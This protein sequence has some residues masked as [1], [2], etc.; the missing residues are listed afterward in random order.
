MSKKA[1]EV[2]LQVQKKKLRGTARL[3]SVCPKCFND[4]KTMIKKNRRPGS[5]KNQMIIRS[6]YLLPK[7]CRK[8]SEHL[9]KCSGT[10]HKQ[11]QTAGEDSCMDSR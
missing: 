10:S 6:L 9:T 5:G 1:L 2:L 8:A 7:C 11:L 4:I 3:S